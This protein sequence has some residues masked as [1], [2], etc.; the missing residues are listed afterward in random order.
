MEA[1]RKVVVRV[2]GHPM[3]AAILEEYG[4]KIA[5]TVRP[6]LAPDQLAI[7]DLSVAVGSW[8]EHIGWLRPDGVP[9]CTPTTPGRFG[10]FTWTMRTRG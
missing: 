5:E 1:G 10:P 8:P 9:R 3:S 6:E 4:A 7:T 2:L